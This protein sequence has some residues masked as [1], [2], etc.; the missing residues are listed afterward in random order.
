MSNKASGRDTQ[1]QQYAIGM[2][3]PVTVNAFKAGW[4]AAIEHLMNTPQYE[5]YRNSSLSY[6]LILRDEENDRLREEKNT[7]FLVLTLVQ[8]EVKRLRDALEL[9]SDARNYA[10]F[11]PHDG[12]KDIRRLKIDSE[13]GEH[14][15]RVLAEQTGGKDE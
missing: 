1:A 7:N 3:E 2:H 10:W 12:T 6:K 8:E 15:R 5:S 14:A 4:D 13:R 11:N 9:Y